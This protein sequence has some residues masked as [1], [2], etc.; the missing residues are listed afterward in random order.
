MGGAYGAVFMLQAIGMGLGA[1]AGGWLYNHFDG[2]G[3]LY[4]G[5]GVMG[6]SAVLI[7]STLRPPRRVVTAT[8]AL[9]TS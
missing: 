3:W 6:A 2:Y 7:A 1:Y 8:A 5:A 9:R 4:A